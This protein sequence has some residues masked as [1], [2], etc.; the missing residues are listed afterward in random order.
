MYNKYRELC[1]KYCPNKVGVV[2]SLS[3]TIDVI[4]HNIPPDLNEISPQ[5]RGLTGHYYTTLVKK[6]KVQAELMLSRKGGQAPIASFLPSL[7]TGSEPLARS[8][9]TASLLALDHL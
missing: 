1:G 7:Q 2:L 8:F 9:L 4:A 5:K 3:S 6:K